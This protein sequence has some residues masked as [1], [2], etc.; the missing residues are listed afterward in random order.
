M[1]EQM[2]LACLM[3]K[4]HRMDPHAMEHTQAFAMGTW[5]GAQALGMDDTGKLA[6][7]MKADVLLLSTNHLAFSPM[8]DPISQIVYSAFPSAVDTTICDG[9]ILMRGRKVLVANSHMVI[10]G[11]RELLEMKG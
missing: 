3:Q 4:V 6:K 10:K 1:M 5:M 11:A 9:K 7:G 2:R 8:N